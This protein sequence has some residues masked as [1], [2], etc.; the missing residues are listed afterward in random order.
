MKILIQRLFAIMFSIISPWFEGEAVAAQTKLRVAIEDT[1]NRPYQYQQEGQ[2][3]GFHIEVI[4]AVTKKLHW[5]IEW[6]PIVWSK[7]YNVLF[8]DKADAI[9][10]LMK[11]PVR[12]EPNIYFNP[13]N[14]IT[15]FELSVYARVDS[16]KVNLTLKNFSALAN[17]NTGVVPGSIADRWFSIVYPEVVLN[18]TPQD[19]L[20]LFQMLDTKRF[21]F[22]IG[23]DYSL[24]IASTVNPRLKDTIIELK[25]HISEAPA[26][27][28]FQNNE[29][30][31]KLGDEFGTAFKAF[32]GSKEYKNLKTKYK[33]R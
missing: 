12:P 14:I 18:R 11:T 30:G 9:S 10:V 8:T 23:N 33:L 28:A 5:Q 13:D 29:H 32:R 22:A 2:W 27:I 6:I 17:H 20:Q 4:E 19:S 16:P 31:R 25:P 1:D 26:F 3:T 15:Y 7:A 21:D 24:N